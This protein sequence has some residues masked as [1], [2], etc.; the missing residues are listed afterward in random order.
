MQKMKKIACVL[1]AVLITVSMAACREN[2]LPTPTPTSTPAPTSGTETNENT[3]EYNEEEHIE[4]LKTRLSNYFDN[5]TT[6]YVKQGE[7]YD[8]GELHFIYRAVDKKTGEVLGT[9]RFPSNLRE[10]EEQ[11][12]D[13]DFEEIWDIEMFGD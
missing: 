9:Y 11:E 13:G 5:P 3:P 2:P 6:D 7:E 1:F 8:D 10:L 12:P 4:F